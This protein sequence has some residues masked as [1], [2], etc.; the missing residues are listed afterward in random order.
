MA[1]SRDKT[2]TEA[3]KKRNDELAHELATLRRKLASEEKE[4]VQVLITLDEK[5]QD[6]LRPH[7]D[8]DLTLSAALSQAFSA[9]KNVLRG[10]IPYITPG[11]YP[12]FSS[13]IGLALDSPA[14]IDLLFRYPEGDSSVELMERLVRLYAEELGAGKVRLRYLGAPGR[15]GLHAKVVICDDTFAIVSS[16]NWTG[17]SLSSNAEAGIGTHSKRAINMLS[18]WFDFTYA[19]A[20]SWETVKESLTDNE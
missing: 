14:R 17:Y 19:N 6:V 7:R 8:F 11:G 4:L 10:A 15:S 20:L 5:A 18:A 9:A 12:D 13:L 3:L 16:A 1:K 2:D